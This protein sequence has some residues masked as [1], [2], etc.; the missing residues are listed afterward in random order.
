MREQHKAEVAQLYADLNKTQPSPVASEDGDTGED[1]EESA[2]VGDGGRE[3][4][5]EV[6]AALA[7]G[8]KD[9]KMK[10]HLGINPIVTLEK[11]RLNMIGK[12]V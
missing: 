6:W 3:A 1:G 7:E 4:S 2:V 9:L 10:V 12:L 8:L 5:E 11:Q